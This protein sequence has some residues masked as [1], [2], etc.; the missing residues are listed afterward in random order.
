MRPSL[1]RLLLAVSIALLL[2]T[3]ARAA[4]I[5]GTWDLPAG[6]VAKQSWTI[7]SAGG[8]GLSGEGSGGPHT[9]PITGTISGNEVR[10]VTSYR[11]TSY[12]AYF[13]GTISPDG[14]TLTGTWDTGSFVNAQTGDPWTATR[15][16][17][18][19]NPGTGTT[20]D[21]TAGRATATQIRCDRG[22]NPG[23]NSVCTATVGDADSSPTPT[24]PSGTVT[25]TAMD[26]GKFNSGNTCTLTP[27]SGS[28]SVSFC[29][30][31]YSPPAKPVFPNVV[32]AYGGSTTHK[33]SAGSTQFLKANISGL[34]PDLPLTLDS[35]NAS[36]AKAPIRKAKASINNSYES[37]DKAGLTTWGE[38]AGNCVYNGANMVGQVG[39]AIVG[40]GGSVVVGV[41]LPVGGVAG[42][43]STGGPGGAVGL[44]IAGA[45]LGYAVASNGLRMTSDVIRATEKARQDPPDPKFKTIAPLAK[46]KKVK[47]STGK[48]GVS[49]KAAAKLSGLLTLQLE[50]AARSRQF[51]ATVDKLGG[52]R[53]AGDKTYTGK[54][55]RASITQAL[56]L[57]KK[58]DKLI[59][60]RKAGIKLIPKSKAATQKLNAKTLA[61]A[62]KAVAG[63]SGAKRLKQLGFDAAGIAFVRQSVAAS[64]ATAD[65]ASVLDVARD[66][67][68]DSML[69]NTAALLRYWTIE[70][71]V[72]A[73]AASR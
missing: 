19:G 31:V 28:P 71:Q 45:G 61:K 43:M 73:D 26:G 37:R 18:S 39:T 64:P 36:V 4:D 33:P 15:R 2:S 49:T 59:A 70:T 14:N 44:G 9:W 3:P 23:D 35:C 6:S 22:P 17:S 29:T 47:V 56:Q 41:A 38:W 21:P 68:Q 8:G 25:F 65:K 69:K 60:A 5:V 24:S 10:I 50:V 52:A 72:A 32:A 67:Q 13:I 1:L 27:T 62:R 42:G 66:A 30:A 16:G 55:A 11:E 20:P 12:T 34:T 58:I 57:A 51:G 7:S 53:K 40:G 48:G 54:Q 63:A 46:V